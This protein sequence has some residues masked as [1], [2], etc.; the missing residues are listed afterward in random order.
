MKSVRALL[1]LAVAVLLVTLL[2]VW[3]DVGVGEVATAL[4]TVDP[5]V[6]ALSTLV[7]GAIYVLRAMRFQALIQ[8]ATRPGLGQLLPVSASHGLAAYVLPV[9]T[10]E[11]SLVLYLRGVCGLGVVE[12][13]AVLLV[14]R[15]LDMTSVAASLGVVCLVL[16]G[17]GSHPELGWL[18]P[19][20]VALV[21]A[22]AV[23]SWLSWRGDRLVDVG[24]KLLVLSGLSKTVLGER[25][26]GVVE[27][28]AGALRGVPRHRLLVGAAVSPGI[29]VCVFLYYA[30]L[31]R[32]LG[33]D[34]IPFPKAVFASSLA[35]L[36][37]LLPVNGFA[38][39]G[40]QDLGWV[41]GY[42]SLGVDREVATTSALAFHL[43]YL[44]HIVSFGLLGHLWMGLGGGGDEGEGSEDP[45]G[46][47]DPGRSAEG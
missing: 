41:V 18:L 31:G 27:R 20:G 40:T 6:L 36:S 19:M 37:N 26:H 9:K 2:V 33:L 46:S 10:G 38:G 32:G 30:V 29:W 14:A 42:T 34:G 28:L 12:G 1:S 17:G 43:V 22:T 7:L 47:S 35:V 4:R 5:S 39:F 13:T 24:A 44:F 16:W 21:L 45:G 8:H 3:S 25:V 15:L 23:F 11:A